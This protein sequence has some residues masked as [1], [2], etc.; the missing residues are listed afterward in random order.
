MR[1]DRQA[2]LGY[3]S[4]ASPAGSLASYL[5]NTR[6]DTA[7]SPSESNPMSLPW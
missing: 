5:A 1:F 4:D 3:I 6:L 7:T 2:E